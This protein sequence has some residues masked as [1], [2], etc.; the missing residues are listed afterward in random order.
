[1]RLLDY[2]NPKYHLRRISEDLSLMRQAMLT[3]RVLSQPHSREDLQQMFRGKLF[4]CFFLSGPFSFVAVAIASYLQYLTRSA[5]VGL[6]ST[7]FLIMLIT[8]IAY[9]FFW[10]IDNRRI[11]ME[12]GSFG[13]AE[14]MAMQRDLWPVHWF[15]M[16][17]GLTFAAVGVPINGAIIGLADLVARNVSRNLPMPIIVIVIDAIVVQGTFVRIMGDFYDRYSHRLA[18]RHFDY[19]SRSA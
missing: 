2:L 13:R 16:R 18:E 7:I 19:L 3:R 12:S 10:W 4:S 6:F 11:Y 5:W 17:T 9:Q 15:G 1:M 8:L 14:F